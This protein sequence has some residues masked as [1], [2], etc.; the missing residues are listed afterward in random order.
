MSI[1]TLSE[2]KAHLRVIGNE[3]DALIQGYIDAAEAHVSKWLNRPLSPWNDDGDPVPTNVKQAI[4]LA[5]GDFY[6][7]RESSILGENRVSNPAFEYLLH[8]ERAELG[9]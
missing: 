1:T 4:L 7:V 2:A 6:E 8:F 9:I 5:V 3:E